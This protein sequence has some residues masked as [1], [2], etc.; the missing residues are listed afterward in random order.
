MA[1][2]KPRGFSKEQVEAIVD[3]LTNT[4]LPYHKIA[5]LHNVSTKGVCNLNLRL[6]IRRYYGWKEWRLPDG[7]SVVLEDAKSNNEKGGKSES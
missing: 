6:N 7:S 1:T 2:Y 4:K 3:S 5:K